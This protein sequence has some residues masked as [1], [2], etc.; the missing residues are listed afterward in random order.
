MLKRENENRAWQALN[1]KLKTLGSV[2][3]ILGVKVTVHLKISQERCPYES[4]TT[5]E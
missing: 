1:V 4:I 5:K 2:R 3:Q